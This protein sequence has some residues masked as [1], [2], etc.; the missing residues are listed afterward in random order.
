M[1]HMVPVASKWYLLCYLRWGGPTSPQMNQGHNGKKGNNITL[2]EQN[3][4]YPQRRRIDFESPVIYTIR[5]I[6]RLDKSWSKRLSGL[7]ILSYHTALI[8]GMEMTKLTGE[9]I[10][11]AA[12]MGVLNALYNLRLTIWSVECLGTP[13]NP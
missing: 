1:D 9:L 13:V 5:I 11:Q 3:P 10:D 8:D 2:E 6:G 12:L 7:N 4:T